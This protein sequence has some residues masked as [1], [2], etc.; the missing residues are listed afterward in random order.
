MPP[1]GRRTEVE[2]KIEIMMTRLFRDRIFAFDSAAAASC[3]RIA[4]A[5]RQ[6]GRPISVADAQIAAIAQ[7]RGA[8]LA[9]RD[10]S[11]FEGCGLKLVNPWTVAQA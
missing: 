8:D 10:I 9:T 5:R 6:A 1:G 2:R 4:S 7:S 11:A 3:A